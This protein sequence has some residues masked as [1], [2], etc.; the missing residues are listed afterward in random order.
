MSF[1]DTFAYFFT[2][3]SPEWWKMLFFSS[4]IY[5][6]LPDIPYTSLKTEMD[7]CATYWNGILN[8]PCRSV[9]PIRGVAQQ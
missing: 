7:L 2:Y 8:S 1:L 5:V 3:I 4:R 6:A 9:I